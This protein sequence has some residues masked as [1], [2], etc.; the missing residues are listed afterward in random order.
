MSELHL[1]YSSME[2]A[3]ADI[4][5]AR[6]ELLTLLGE[7]QAEVSG[8]GS[9]FHTQTASAGFEASIGDFVTSMTKAVTDMQSLEKMLTGTVETFTAADTALADGING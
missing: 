4:A 7:V 1:V 9:D 3:A 6:T 2:A 8:L 5:S